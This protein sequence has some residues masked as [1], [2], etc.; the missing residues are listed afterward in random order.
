LVVTIT[1]LKT[2]GKKLYYWTW[3]FS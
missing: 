2:I 3:K 1:V